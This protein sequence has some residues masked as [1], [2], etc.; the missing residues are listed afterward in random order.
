MDQGDPT[1][2]AL[3]VWGGVGWRCVCRQLTSQKA[4]DA[5]KKGI[6]QQWLLLLR[7][8][9]ILWQAPGT[10]SS[11]LDTCGTCWVE[12]TEQAEQ[13]GVALGLARG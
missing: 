11:P 13:G 10:S 5:V 8:P 3:G 12:G 7:I 4:A 2:K 6:F 9:Q 1:Q